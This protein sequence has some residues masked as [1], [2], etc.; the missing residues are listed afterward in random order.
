MT[1]CVEGIL[2][3]RPDFYGLKLEPAIPSEWENFEIDKDFRGKHLHIVVSNKGHAETG[4]KRLIVNEKELEGNYIPIELL[5]EKT[6][7][8]LEIS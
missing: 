3:I 5:T 2:G 4:C 6:E 8:I 7:I 1:G